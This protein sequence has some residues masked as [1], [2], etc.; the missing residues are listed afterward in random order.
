MSNNEPDFKYK[1]PQAR[2][3]P[4]DVSDIDWNKIFNAADSR[5][6][7]KAHKSAIASK[8]KRESGETYTLALQMLQEKRDK[9]SSTG[10]NST[11]GGLNPPTST[12]PSATIKASST[13][14][15]QPLKGPTGSSREATPMGLSTM[16]MAERIKTEGRPRKAASTALSTAPSEYDT[17]AP[18][19]AP[20]AEPSKP[21]PARKK[22][23]AAPTKKQQLNK[24]LTKSKINGM[25]IAPLRGYCSIT[26]NRYKAS[27]PSSSRQASHTPGPKSGVSSGDE[28]NDGGEYCLCGGPDDHRMMVFCEGGCEDWYHCSCVGIDEE[29]A[30]ELLDRFIC[31]KCKIP[32]KAF[33]TYRPMC[34]FHNVGTF[35]NQPACRKAARVT[36]DPPSKY[37][38]DEHKDAFWTFVA[39]RVRQDTEPS[40]GGTLNRGEVFSI[41]KQCENVEDFR[42]LGEKPRLPEGEAADPGMPRFPDT[43]PSIYLTLID[44][45]VGL[46]YL[47]PEEEKMLEDMKVKKKDIELKIEGYQ[48]QLKLLN[49]VVDR[50]KVAGQHLKEAKPLCGYDNRLAFNE[51]QFE[52]WSKTDEGKT[53]LQTGI[54]GPRTD[55]TK[56]I[57]AHVL[58][59][60]QAVPEVPI[61]PDVLNNIC[62]SLEKAK[63]KHNKLSPWKEVH[64]TDLAFNMKLLRDQLSKLTIQEAEII[65]DAETREASKEYYADNETI[66]LF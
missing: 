39:G 24:S 35:L 36:G 3:T 45:P 1:Y 23:T 64:R 66:Q 22:G 7:N 10:N 8:A 5:F 16:D 65:D 11:I 41:L 60:G 63:C 32:G 28:S 61:V 30:K 43:F 27:T 6:Y 57:N 13:K 38:S 46:N 47:L 37:C 42:A 18:S 12:H 29:D 25:A 20:K 52:R 31:P 14:K 51:P 55:E 54:L 2:P 53:A 34:R 33:T 19:L 48:N 26:A 58:F 56:H 21:K 9:A 50:A 40:K 44:H 17:S 15:P 59:A 62:L 49:M 4:P